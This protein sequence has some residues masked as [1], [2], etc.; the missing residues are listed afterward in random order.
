MKSNLSLIVDGTFQWH[1]LQESN[2][3]SGHSVHTP[4]KISFIL[5][6]FKFMVH[7]IAEVCYLEPIEFLQS[8]SKA[9]FLNIY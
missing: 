1:E 8:L 6:V 9:S 5:P 4:E 3:T 2:N 7:S